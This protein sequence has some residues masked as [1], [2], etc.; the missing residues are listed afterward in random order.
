MFVA[1]ET[2]GTWSL[3]ADVESLVRARS[4]RHLMSCDI[5]HFWFGGSDGPDVSRFLLQGIHWI[6]HVATQR[7]RRSGWNHT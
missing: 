1:I 3:K 2:G 5:L 7:L 4:R 6:S